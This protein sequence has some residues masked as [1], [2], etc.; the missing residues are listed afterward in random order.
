[1]AGS[2]ARPGQ[3]TFQ[4]LQLIHP[5][6]KRGDPYRF[7]DQL[8]DRNAMVQYILALDEVGQTGLAALGTSLTVSAG[9]APRK[10][11]FFVRAPNEMIQICSLTISMIEI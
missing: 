4:K 8:D 10:G 11:V 7:F 6:S 3:K 2:T 5:D 1:M 9:S